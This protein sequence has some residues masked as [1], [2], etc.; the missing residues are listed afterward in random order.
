LEHLL[1]DDD[2]LMLVEFCAGGGVPAGSDGVDIVMTGIDP[3]HKLAP[4][5][6]AAKAGG[7]VTSDEDE[8]PLKVVGSDVE[9][10][11][12]EKVVDTHDE[13]DGDSPICPSTGDESESDTDLKARVAKSF[14][15]IAPAPVPTKTPP[16]AGASLN[17]RRIV[18][19]LWQDDS[20]SGFAMA[21][22]T[23]CCKS[24]SGVSTMAAWWT[25][26][27]R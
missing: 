11:G 1:A 26:H 8:P 21:P 23:T 9:E 5:P 18:P 6:P 13:S 2:V 14:L 20:T 22:R 17:P 4:S 3:I 15:R 10:S 7:D 19:P 16:P 27:R 12:C 25:A 24:G